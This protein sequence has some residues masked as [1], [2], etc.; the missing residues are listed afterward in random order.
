MNNLTDN[1]NIKSE[2]KLIT[3]NELIDWIP[4]DAETAKNI[5]MWRQTTIDIIHKK[6]DRLL[7]IVWPCSIHNTDEA[8]E[9]ATKLKKLEKKYPNLFIVMRTYF[10]KPRTTIWWK[11]LINDPDL[12]KSY[13]MDKWLKKARQLLV[14]VSK[15]WLPVSTEILDP[16]SPQF[17][18]DLITWWAIWARTTESQIHREVASWSSA[19]IW[20]KNW[21][22]WDT[23]IAIDWIL[24]ANQPH[25][26]MW[27]WKD[28][29]NKGIN[30]K[31]NKNCHIILRWGKWI[32]NY[33]AQ[34]IQETIVNLE[35]YD[36][37][38]WIMVDASHA[39]SLKDHNN[40]IKVI[41]EVSKQIKNGE[42]NIIWVMIESNINAWNQSF[43]PW[44]DNP[45]NIQ[46]WISIT[47]K[48]VDMETT[49]N[50][51]NM[52]NIANENN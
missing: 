49:E 13:N 50:M 10:E 24:S 14:D 26:F 38:T 19:I 33:N 1:I 39:N 9:Y 29:Q 11:W 21:T 4:L 36:I 3:P 17:I 48:C 42:N 41:E 37:D 30:S 52:L 43:N 23:Q 18:S 35:K 40:Q 27:M 5:M 45:Q 25:S 16:M 47:D 44:I 32:T 22:T 46:Y 6:D 12:D 20:F 51:L 28:G 34:S 31:W 15:I 2:T 8:L 7:T